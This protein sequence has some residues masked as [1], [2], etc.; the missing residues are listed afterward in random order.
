MPNA[1]IYHNPRCSKSRQALALLE[2]ASVEVTIVKYLEAPPSAQ[3]LE[4]LLRKLDMEPQGLIRSS[5][6][7]YQ[8]LQLAGKTLSRDEAIQLLVENPILIERPIVTVG[9]R[10]VVGRPPER[11]KELLP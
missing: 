9:N 5:E 11:V 1:I 8:E 6:D 4:D 2:E 10:A 7:R 3:E